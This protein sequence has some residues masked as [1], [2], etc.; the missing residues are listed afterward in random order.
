MD[1]GALL[2]YYKRKDIQEA[3]V[4]HCRDREFSVRYGDSFGKRPDILNYPRDVI[5]SVMSG[6]TS[7]HCSEERWSNPLELS[8]EIKKQEMEELRSAW[9]LVLDIDCPIFEY[10]RIAAE[11]I[12]KFL[13]YCG[14]KG[15]SCKFSGNKGFHIGVPFEAFPKRALDSETR[16][17]FPEAPKKI[18][19]Y[20]K[21]NIKEELGKRLME[22]ENG[23]FG[24]IKEKTGF[25]KKI[26]RYEKDKLG[27]DVAKLNVDPFL[28]IDTILIAPRHLYRMPYSLHEKSGLASV[29]VEP[30][31]VKDFEKEMGRPEKVVVSE[32]KFLDQNVVE[33]SGRRLLLQALDFEAKPEEKDYEGD[34]K[35]RGQI[36]QVEGAIKEE[37]FP[38]C[39]KLILEGLEDG[40]KRAV[41]SLMNFLGKVGWEKKEIKRFLLKWNREK[42]KDGLR[43]NLIISQLNYFKG[44]KLPPNC[45]NEAY[46]LDI[47]VCKP[48]KLCERVK[49]PVNYTLRKWKWVRM[50]E[51]EK[52]KK[53]KGKKKDK[54]VPK[55]EEKRESKEEKAF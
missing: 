22:F 18:A 31:K 45:D 39:V 1:K 48:D 44:D 29:M 32:L 50:L 47:G 6:A 8:S 10:S 15:I 37:L 11:L 28:E 21:E 24:K 27:N 43:E 51:K 16:I 26:I 49:N 30:D 46:Y 25:D 35:F 23:D 52:E 17:L 13:K 42:N 53:E 7:F 9:D 19:G 20:I 55:E 14:V 5:E 3:M 4:E 41:F 34:K 36:I 54:A 12:I 33:D 2:R 40:K 38:P